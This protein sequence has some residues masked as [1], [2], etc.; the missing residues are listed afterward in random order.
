MHRES[1]FSVKKIISYLRQHWAADFR[2]GYY[3]TVTVFLAVTISLNY[4]LDFEDN[5]I[6]AY[7]G[8]SIRVFYYFLL[9]AF[10]YYA[11]TLIYT[12]FRDRWSLWQR[13]GF[14]VRSLFCLA[15]LSLDKSFHYHNYFIR[16]Y[17]PSETWLYAIRLTKQ[18]LSMLTSVLPLYL[19]YRFADRQSKSFY[20]LTVRGFDVRPYAM[21]LALMVPLIVAASFNEGF[22]RTYP[23]YQEAGVVAFWEVPEWIPTLAYE[24]AYGLDFLSIELLFRGFMVLGM[25]VVMGRAAVMPMVVTYAFLHFGKPAGETVSSIF[26]GYILGVI[27]YQSRSVF[28]G[29]LIHVGI[30]WLMEL[31]AY[32]QKEFYS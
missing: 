21:M 17:L 2:P 30:A 19:F 27:A 31:A 18:L 20:G 1:S 6:D 11:A 14:W 29:V 16:S 5:V 12:A 13:P 8:Q 32:V 22:L 15:V 26:G 4:H 7:Y 9:Y 23:R 24:L 10:A 25:A 3:A 28:G